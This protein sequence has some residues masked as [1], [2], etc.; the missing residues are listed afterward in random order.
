MFFVLNC[1]C[2]S[3]HL[4]F[5]FSF[6]FSENQIDD[7]V[8]LEDEDDSEIQ[9]EAARVVKGNIVFEECLPLV[10]EA[11]IF[12]SKWAASGFAVADAKLPDCTPESTLP[13]GRTLRTTSASVGQLSTVATTSTSLQFSGRRSA[14]RMEK[15]TRL[16]LDLRI[17]PTNTL[18]GLSA[19][20]LRHSLTN[21]LCLQHA[22][23]FLV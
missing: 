12:M 1:L 22:L 11:H 15:Q 19:A 14:V 16:L 4:K 3:M 6:F 13:T 20:L 8:I 7:F 9:L 2:C 10:W 17:W 5:Y 23:N 21:K 18:S